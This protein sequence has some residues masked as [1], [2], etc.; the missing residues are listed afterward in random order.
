M[1][2]PAAR[3]AVIAATV[4]AVLVAG[5]ASAAKAPDLVTAAAGGQPVNE[6]AAQQSISASAD[7]TRIAF[8]SAAPD[9]VPGDTNGVPD[10]FL[11]DLTAGTLTRI[12]VSIA[13][14]QAN[15]ASS[16]AEISAD[17]AYVVFSS[18]ASNLVSGDFNGTQD[19]FV[20]DVAAGTTARV[21]VTRSGIQGV[22]PSG[23]A[24]SSISADG[25]FVTFSS[26]SANLV[27]A[28]TN[29]A[30]DVL[31]L[32][33]STGVIERANAA[34]DGG[35]APSGTDS[36]ASAVS[37]DGRYVVVVTTAALDSSDA[38][39]VADVYRRDRQ[40]GATEL[41]SVGTTAA[42]DLLPDGVSAACGGGALRP[43]PARTPGDTKGV[44]D[45]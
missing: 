24:P 16:N 14:A 12:S 42:V 22:A 8:V 35:Q 32:D 1:R 29:G 37:A 4:G 2:V 44:Y 31:V 15:R 23:E 9:L 39:G 25:R 13:G 28:D 27:S 7:G 20:R 19:V 17:G 30:R 41:V 36:G 26:R 21:S 33:R 34:A 11:R 10:V 45:V 18:L 38:D 40:A 5:S 43:P 6:P 3:V